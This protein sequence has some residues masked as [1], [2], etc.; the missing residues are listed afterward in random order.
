M[1]EGQRISIDWEGE[2]YYGTYSID[3]DQVTVSAHNGRLS[4]H[5]NGLSASVVAKR[6]LRDLAQ[7]GLA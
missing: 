4:D 5:L 3:R 7:R 6:L 1:T 2:T